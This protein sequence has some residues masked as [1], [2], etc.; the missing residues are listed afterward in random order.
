MVNSPCGMWLDLTG[1]AGG[2]GPSL[3]ETQRAGSSPIRPFKKS[4]CVRPLPARTATAAAATPTAI[5]A[6]AA[7]PAASAI[8]ARRTAAVALFALYNLWRYFQVRAQ[9]RRRR[10][11]GAPA[12]QAV[13][14]KGRAARGVTDPLEKAALLVQAGDLARDRVGDEALAAA[15]YLRALH[16][17]KGAQLL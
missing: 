9:N 11:G 14:D 7:T 15:Y 17:D 12:L 1:G 5:A 3:P 10:R 4:C 6:E 16:A 8:A 13:R 2:R